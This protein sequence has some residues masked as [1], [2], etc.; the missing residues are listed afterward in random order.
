MA[1]PRRTP[2]GTVRLTVYVA[3]STAA[4]LRRRAQ[5]R[6][7]GALLDD[8]VRES[9]DAGLYEAQGD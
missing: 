5:P 9:E 3:P 1:R 2:E 8:I 6:S 7:V 4:E